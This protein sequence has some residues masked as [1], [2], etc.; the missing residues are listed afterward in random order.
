MNR[1][2][3][4]AAGGNAKEGIERWQKAQQLRTQRLAGGETNVKL[5]ADAGKG[6][7]NL[8]RFYID[9]G[10]VAAAEKHLKESVASFERLRKEAPDD[11]DSQFMLAQCYRALGDLQPTDGDESQA[12][13]AGAAAQAYYAKAF[14]LL[15]TLHLRNPQ[16]SQYQSNLGGVQTSVA[17]L[18]LHDGKPKEALEAIEKAVGPLSELVAQEPDVLLD[19]RDL[20]VALR[21]RAAIHLK[22]ADRAAA[23]SDATRAVELLQSLVSAEPSDEDYAAQLEA[24]KQTLAD[25]Q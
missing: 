3:I 10:N 19:Q 1:G 9:E 15:A 24:A 13:T 4:E 23:L 6:D 21:L 17:E 18:L 20:A 5:R 14:D 12:K 16:V 8:G 11:L 25:S 2:S 7:F 22:L